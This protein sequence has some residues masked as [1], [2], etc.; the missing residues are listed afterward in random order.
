MVS[1]THFRSTIIHR[2]DVYSSWGYDHV[3]AIKCISVIRPSV[4]VDYMKT[5]SIL[6]TR[7]S[8]SSPPK[9]AEMRHTLWNVT[10]FNNT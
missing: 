1:E 8:I 9:G 3:A 2:F 4:H 5:H 6:R 10:S 7:W